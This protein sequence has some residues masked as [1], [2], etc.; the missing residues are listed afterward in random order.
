MLCQ[1]REVV[2]LLLND[3]LV[4]PPLCNTQEVFSLP[5]LWVFAFFL[6]SWE[7]RT[8]LDNSSLN[9]AKAFKI[10]IALIIIN[11]KVLWFNEG[12]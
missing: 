2:D 7:Q 6:N 8:C 10:L 9:T 5:D 12:F 4:C 3:A 11:S 1:F